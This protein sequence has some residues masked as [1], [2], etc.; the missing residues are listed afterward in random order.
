MI[1]NLNRSVFMGHIGADAKQ[2]SAT[3]PVTFS[4]AVSSHW[5]DTTGDR[6]TR[7][8]WQ[9]IVVFGNLR[10]YA[11]KLKKGDRVYIEAEARNNNYERKINTETVKFYETEFLAAAI[12]RVAVKGDAEADE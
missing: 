8:D 11:A 10:K 7:T 1:N 9:S 3:A 6:Q 2:A 4:I 5:T 12:E